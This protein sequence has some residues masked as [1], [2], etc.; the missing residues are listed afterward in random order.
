MCHSFHAGEE[1]LALS[2][3]CLAVK[4]GIEADNDAGKQIA[5]T[6]LALDI[7]ANFQVVAHAFSPCAATIASAIAWARSASFFVVAGSVMRPPV[8]QD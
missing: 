3:N 8:S 4:L 7:I 6:R 5:G 2:M 1:A